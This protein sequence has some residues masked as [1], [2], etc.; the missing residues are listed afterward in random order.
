VRAMSAKPSTILLAVALLTL[1]AAAASAG[2]PY[3]F[4]VSCTAPKLDYLCTVGAR[5]PDPGAAAWGHYCAERVRAE[6]GHAQCAARALAADCHAKRAFV[7]RNSKASPRQAEALV[8]DQPERRA[9]AAAEIWQATVAGMQEVGDT[10]DKGAGAVG[11]VVGQGAEAV[12][13]GASDVG[14]G[15]VE[16][17]GAVGRGV[18]RGTDCVWSLGK[19]C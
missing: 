3:E 9:G 15:M 18:S 7:F 6:A 8:S 17:L 12:S 19:R 1:P 10:V 13:E 11:R 16:G 2:G 4:C 14:Q 5:E